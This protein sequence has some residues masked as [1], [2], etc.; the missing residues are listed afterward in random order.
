MSL[1]LCHVFDAKLSVIM[2]YVVNCHAERRYAMFLCYSECHYDKFQYD[3]CHSTLQVGPYKILVV[4]F[5]TETC[6]HF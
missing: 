4:Y 2:L 5:L 6:Q 3:V 1:L